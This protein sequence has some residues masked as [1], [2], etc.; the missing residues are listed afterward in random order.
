MGNQNQAK[1]FADVQYSTLLY[2]TN[3]TQSYRAYEFAVII[4][5]AEAQGACNES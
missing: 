2:Y 5:G 4:P 1:D 3:L